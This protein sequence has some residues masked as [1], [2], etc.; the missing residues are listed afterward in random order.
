MKHPKPFVLKTEL[1][2]YYP[3]YQIN[4]YIKEAD[5]LATIYSNLHQNIQDMFNE[6]GVEILSPH[7]F[8]QRDGNPV[9]MP[10]EYVN[11]KKE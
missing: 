9:A 11:T 3:C 2:D 1:H 8:A 6:A 5:K 7:Y 4:A 10:P